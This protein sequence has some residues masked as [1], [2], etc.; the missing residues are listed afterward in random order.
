MYCSK[1][2]ATINGDAAFCPACGTP[3]LASGSPNAVNQ[4]APAGDAVPNYMVGAILTTLFCCLIGG[5][6]AIVFSSQV[7]TKLAQ[8]DIE[9][10][11]AASKT[12]KIWIIVNLVVGLCF[13]L[14]SFT[15]AAIP[16]Y[17]AYLNES[18]ISAT[19]TRIENVNVAI[20]SYNI[21]HGRYPESL[22]TLTKSVDNEDPLL[23]DG[24]LIDPWGN[25][26][27]YERRGRK[28]PLISSAGPDGEFDTADDLT[29]Y[30]E[31][32]KFKP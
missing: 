3:V 26:L 18:R 15:V 1:C 16:I 10:A 22:T 32:S 17:M 19:R 27:K 21:M 25:E 2:G 8:G 13:A 9:G 31:R 29:N 12:A 23:E 24:E 4:T 7:N 11:K 28:R 6:V 14:I 30:E 5:I 20:Q